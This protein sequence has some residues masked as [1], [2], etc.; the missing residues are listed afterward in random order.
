[1]PSYLLLLLPA[2]L[3]ASFRVPASIQVTTLQDQLDSPAGAECSLRE[4]IRDASGGEEITFDPSLSQPG[5]PA[6]IR[7]R[8]EW[9]YLEARTNLSIDASGL[10]GGLT[11]SGEE[12]VRILRIQ[13]NVVA[14]VACIRFE[15]GS[16]P[17]IIAPGQ[18][19]L[20]RG[21]GIRNDGFLELENCSFFGNTCALN[22]SALSNMQ[23]AV[24]RN[25]FFEGNPRT[26]LRNSGSLTAFSCSFHNNSL[27][28]SNGGALLNV[29]DAT[30]E[31][32]T[33]QGNA[34]EYG[35]AIYNFLVPLRL[36][37]CTIVDNVALYGGGVWDLVSFSTPAG[38][39]FSNCIISLNSGWGDNVSGVYR[40][41][42]PNLLGGNPSLYPF[43][44]YGGPV[45]TMPPA[46]GSTVIDYLTG[47]PALATDA[48]GV[49]RPDGASDLGAAEALEP[50][51]AAHDSDADGMD[52][53]FEVLYGLDAT[54]DDAGGDIDGDLVSNGVEMDARTNP[55]DASD[56]PALH[57]FRCSA[58]SQAGSE[59]VLLRWRS[60]FGQEFDLWR[61][62][63]PDGPL[64][65]IN[66]DPVSAAGGTNLTTALQFDLATP[67]PVFFHVT[68]R[69]PAV[70]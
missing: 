55:R 58:G 7:L 6:V 68:R 25:C 31:N 44:D 43:G 30:L 45:P 66:A 50:D 49:T 24:L 1:M 42:G 14:R 53:R 29:G 38:M 4:A 63:S 70:P 41:T 11:L 33:F 52:D 16:A 60:V 46:P 28:A 39:E 54:I 35:G 67:A 9:G 37:H 62:S 8:P 18:E 59:G 15:R 2:V 19:I 12:N 47:A 51:P 13:T 10:D 27:G 48:R 57:A 20:N 5:V 69:P 21:G 56:R 40:Q 17:G 36:R 26:A 64:V 3:L 32:C 23:T 61:S 65:Q 22:G 34:A